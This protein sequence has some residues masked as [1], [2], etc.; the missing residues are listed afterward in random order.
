MN[1]PHTL[2]DCISVLL[3]IVDGRLPM[4]PLSILQALHVGVLWVLASSLISF[5]F[6]LS[7]RVHRW[8]IVWIATWLIKLC[9]SRLFLLN[10]CS[11]LCFP[12]SV[13]SA[14]LKN[15]FRR[16]SRSPTTHR[17][18]YTLMERN[19]TSARWSSRTT[20]A[21]GRWWPTVVGISGISSSSVAVIADT[22]GTAGSPTITAAAAAI[23]LSSTGMSALLSLLFSK[24]NQ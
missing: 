2:F 5:P 24:D 1:T 9:C 7:G 19:A 21:S 17:I 6:S 11:S 8:G 18:T 15:G 22:T 23:A 12:F 3:V 16:K 10:K 14:L 20:P 13:Q 4:I